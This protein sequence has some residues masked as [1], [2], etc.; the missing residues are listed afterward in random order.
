MWRPTARSASTWQAGSACVPP[1]HQA[2]S[3]PSGEHGETPRPA[4]EVLHCPGRFQGSGAFS[5]A[6]AVRRRAGSREY[7]AVSAAAA[8]NAEDSVLQRLGLLVVA[9]EFLV[10]DPP[11][12][13]PHPQWPD[14]PP[15]A[16][17]LCCG[18]ATCLA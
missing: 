1:H 16:C 13:A 7:M 15:Q 8:S 3:S 12:L 2:T 5:T 9:V 14:Q 6:S 4:V 18:T 10:E 17:S 11:A